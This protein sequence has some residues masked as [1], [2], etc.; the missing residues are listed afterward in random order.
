MEDPKLD[1]L[2][3]R[4]TQLLNKVVLE[5]MEMVKETAKEIVSEYCEKTVST[6]KEN[7]NLRR[8]LLE[9]QNILHIRGL[10]PTQQEA[11]LLQNSNPDPVTWP[12]YAS[13]SQ[14]ERASD[15][16]SIQQCH[17][18]PEYKPEEIPIVQTTP[19]YAQ[20]VKSEPPCSISSPTSQEQYDSNRPT[21]PDGAVNGETAS[22]EAA[23]KDDGHP[24]AVCGKT[25]TRVGYLKIHLRCHTGEKPY[26]CSQCGK[27]FR[28]G[29]D[30]KKHK[31]VHTG[32]KPYYC[33]Q[34]GKTFNR[35]EN[36]KRHRKVHDGKT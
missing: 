23:R 34:C 19:E 15:Q 28:Q 16:T 1:S 11:S 30:L 35:A 9:I 7:E 5:V 33:D 4:V 29:S 26:V 8:S 12:N 36:M 10:F 17:R 18:E 13:F 32:E 21:Y 20:N 25:F 22:T 6:L 2:N 3:A 27:R 24:C 31:I 14:P